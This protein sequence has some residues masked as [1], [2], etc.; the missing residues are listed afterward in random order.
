MSDHTFTVESARRAAQQGELAT[1]VHDF[2]G[3]D[4]SDNAELGEMLT[5]DERWWAGPMLLPIGELNRLV[6]PPGDP[7]LCPIVDDDE[8]RD[9][10]D[11]M[12]AAIAEDEW[13]PPPV[14]VTY[15]NGQLVLEDGNHRVEGLR[16][17]D[18]DEAWAVVGFETEVDRDRFW[19]ALSTDPGGGTG[20]GE[21]S[22]V[23]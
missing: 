10:I 9:D 2:L 15:R 5:E 17:A 22:S 3:S 8:W 23:S 6:G 11:E 21:G 19:A 4:G 20:Q 13:N 18:E 14:V 16:R 12:A 1:W 7:V